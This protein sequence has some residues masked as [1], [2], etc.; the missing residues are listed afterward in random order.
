EVPARL[1]EIKVELAWLG[2]RTTSPWA[3]TAHCCGASLV[4]RGEVPSNAARQHALQ[5]ASLAT[6][7]PVA[8]ALRVRSDLH[9]TPSRATPDELRRGVVSV[10]CEMLGG[11]A[12]RVEVG[13]RAGGQV[14]LRG[15]VPS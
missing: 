3:L 1:Q 15:T 11:R 8:D 4:I 2:D 10:L 6:G 12:G 9:A 14:T 13:T 5:L 7:L